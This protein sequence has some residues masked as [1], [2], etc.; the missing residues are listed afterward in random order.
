MNGDND[1]FARGGVVFGPR[2]AGEDVVPLRSGVVHPVPHGMVYIGP[3]DGG[4]WRAIGRL[5]DDGI[6]VSE[7]VEQ[8]DIVEQIDRATASLCPCGAEPSEDFAPYCS[9]DCKPTHRARHT[10]SD[11]DGTQMRW[12]P[13]LVSEVDDTGLRDLGS[14]TFY[15]GRFRAQLF[16]RG[17]EVDGVV[18]WHLR[19]DDGYRFV[20]ADLRDVRDVDDAL[21]ERV[22]AK[23]TALERE[24]E[25]ERHAVPAEVEQESLAYAVALAEQAARMR[26]HRAQLASRAVDVWPDMHIHWVNPPRDR[27]ETLRRVREGRNSGPQRAPRPPR[28]ID[29]RRGR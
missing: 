1:R 2:P 29:P 3:A 9:Y 25:N 21:L 11:R 20:G 15:E 19:L 4:Q 17:S 7:T 14:N 10:I 16:Q 24:L 5:L 18:T 28:N 13:D 27:M 22:A 6:A 23:W 12:R 8:P 26:A